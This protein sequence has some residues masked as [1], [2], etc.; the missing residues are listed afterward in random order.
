MLF[1]DSVTGNTFESDVDEVLEA[2]NKL[3]HEFYE[4]LD[5][6]YGNSG[7]LL[8]K[9]DLLISEEEFTKKLIRGMDYHSVYDEGLNKLFYDSGITPMLEVEFNMTI[10]D[11][12]PVVVPKYSLK[13][14]G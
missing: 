14:F 13:H 11:G 12:E 10:I 5:L 1:Y 4:D 9:E 6:R 8:G 7:K 3:N 2:V